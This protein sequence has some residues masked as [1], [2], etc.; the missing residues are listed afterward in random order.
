MLTLFFF[1]VVPVG[2]SAAEDDSSG[3]FSEDYPAR[4]A[5]TGE[6]E[7]D[8][9]EA[10][11]G[12]EDDEDEEDD[13]DAGFVESLLGHINDTSRPARE[14]KIKTTLKHLQRFIA[15]DHQKFTGIGVEPGTDAG[16]LSYKIVSSEEFVGTFCN[17]LAKEATYLSPKRSSEKLTY[18]TV[19]GYASTFCTYYTDRFRDRDTPQPLRPEKWTKK[20]QAIRHVC[21]LQNP[22]HLACMLTIDLFP[23][24]KRRIIIKVRG[25]E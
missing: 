10:G 13:E 7:G 16:D 23:G 22:I 5:R 21:N 9:S 3:T 18:A 17:Y 12:A 24:K 19:S 15:G 25:Q 6:G 1:L 20:M 8:D 14:R 11:G 4:A 2:V